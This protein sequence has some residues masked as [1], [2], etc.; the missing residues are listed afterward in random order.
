MSKLEVGNAPPGAQPLSNL[1]FGQHLKFWEHTA[2][3]ALVLELFGMS[4][5]AWAFTSWKAFGIL[6]LLALAATSGGGV[7]GFLFGVPRVKTDADLGGT[8]RHNSNLEQISDWLTKVI[9]GAT[10]VQ[11]TDIVRAIGGVSLF[12]G[13]EISKDGSVTAA[14]SVMVFS[15]FAGFMWGY[16][17]SSVRVKGELDASD[18]PLMRASSQEGSVA[19]TA[20]TKPSVPDE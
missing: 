15:F 17:W 2:L 18:A 8:F 1:G 4:I 12:I 20:A 5:Y 6:F 13:G 7:L 3:Y 10:L 16:L 14:C 11:I 9:I 19:R